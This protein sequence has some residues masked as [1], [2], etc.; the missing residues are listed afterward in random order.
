MSDVKL[1]ETQE[2]LAEAKAW[3]QEKARHAD[4]LGR[5]LK[6]AQDAA[7]SAESVAGELAACQDALAASE[8]RV[9]DLV[10]EVAAAEKR[11]RKNEAKA[12]RFDAIKS[13]LGV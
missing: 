9:A 2:K 10:S 7:A 3:G 1:K 6:A 11:A 8:A 4:Q 12:D 13:A 5:E